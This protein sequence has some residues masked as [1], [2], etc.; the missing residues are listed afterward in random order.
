MRTTCKIMNKIEERSS[1][2]F[3]TKYNYKITRDI[4]LKH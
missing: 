3:K 1:F 2:D 4:A